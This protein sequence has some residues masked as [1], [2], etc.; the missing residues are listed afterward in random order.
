MMLGSQQ[1]TRTTKVR[2]PS[3]ALDGLEAL[4]VNSDTEDGE[5][6]DK[7]Y[8]DLIEK[9][10]NGTHNNQYIDTDNESELQ[11]ATQLS[12]LEE[13][14]RA[15]LPSAQPY[16]ETRILYKTE[17]TNDSDENDDNDNDNDND[18]EEEDDDIDE[19]ENDNDNDNNNSSS[20]SVYESEYI[21]E[22]VTYVIYFFLNLFV[23][24]S[25]AICYPFCLYSLCFVL[26]CFCFC[27]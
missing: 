10:R 3:T 1:R 2:R 18:D 21:T 9:S 13:Q 6:A 19:N 15:L 8:Q 16:T 22:S 5:K 26:F 27:F 17:Y 4:Q 11:Q 23:W 7:W 12:Q 24:F 14:W 20:E 25:F